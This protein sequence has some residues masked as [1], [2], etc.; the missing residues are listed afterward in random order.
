MGCPSWV[1]PLAF[2]FCLAH[3]Y[4]S[5]QPMHF[6]AAVAKTVRH[7]AVQMQI[8]FFIVYRLHKE[9][10][11]KEIKNDNDNL[12]LHT[13]TKLSGWLRYCRAEYATKHTF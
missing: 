12:N 2:L 8:K 3:C 11:S 4:T 9:S 10:I 7:L 5:F 1:I 13:M 6:M